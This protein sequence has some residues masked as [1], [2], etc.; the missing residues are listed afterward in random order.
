M[1]GLVGLSVKKRATNVV[2]LE[3]NFLP[4]ASVNRI[5]VDCRNEVWTGWKIHSKRHHRLFDRSVKIF[6]VLSCDSNKLLLLRSMG[7]NT[8]QN[9][10]R[11]DM[12]NIWGI[13][14]FLVTN[15]GFYFQIVRKYF[16]ENLFLSVTCLI[17]IVIEQQS[18]KASKN[19]HLSR[20]VCSSICTRF[21]ITKGYDIFLN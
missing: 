12:R 14:S 20:I 9:I 17:V 3:T 15:L 4:W 21:E 2:N 6:V 19:L 18:L 7:S 16:F 1:S 10:Y 13:Q 8:E 11:N 5:L